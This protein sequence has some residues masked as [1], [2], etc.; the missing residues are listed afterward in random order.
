MLLWNRWHPTTAQALPEN[1]DGYEQIAR[2][3]IAGRGYSSD[4]SGI[5]GFA[6]NLSRTPAYPWLLVAIKTIFGDKRPPIFYANAVLGAMTAAMAYWLACRWWG[7]RAGITAGLFASFDIMS[8][9]WCAYP[10]AEML[11][12]MFT[13]L[14]F[15]IFAVGSERMRD[16]PYH[17]KSWVWMV[18][19]G[20]A[21]SLAALTKPIAL[22]LVFAAMGLLGWICRR[23]KP[24]LL[25]SVLMLIVWLGLCGGWMVRNYLVTKRVSQEKKGLICFS[26]ISTENLLIY[27]G[28]QIL[29]FAEKRPLEEVMGELRRKIHV[30]NVSPGRSIEHVSPQI[31]VDIDAYEAE[32][33][34]IIRAHPFLLLRVQAQGMARLF[35]GPGELAT[36]T[37]FGIGLDSD[38]LNAM[39]RRGSEGGNEAAKQNRRALKG[40]LLA[41]DVVRVI[42]WGWLAILY[43][44]AV[45]GVRWLWKSRQWTPLLVLT[46]GII[47]FAGLAGGPEANSRFRVP[48]VPYLAM[49]AGA[50]LVAFQTSRKKI[51][52]DASSS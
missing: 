47:Y 43:F 42:G 11:L 28:A 4:M 44:P 32:A 29:S 7:H 9:I 49:I 33:W 13:M 52:T 2:N 48:I 46:T 20:G 5:L 30:A 6:P 26:T 3:L 8:I 15:C 37:L 35:L 51:E 41:R 36:L 12:T 1:I 39:E 27:R 17:W 25:G 24:V 23:A 40:H 18:G 50:G 38:S 10:R 21:F 22:F 19:A 14:G 16:A 45:L 34:R 31:G